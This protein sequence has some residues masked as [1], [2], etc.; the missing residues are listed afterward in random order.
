[1][2][3]WDNF[4]SFNIRHGSKIWCHSPPESEKMDTARHH[5]QMQAFLVSRCNIFQNRHLYYTAPL[6]H[7]SLRACCMKL[8]G[9]REGRNNILA[10]SAHIECNTHP[11]V[12]IICF[13]ERIALLSLEMTDPRKSSSLMSSC[14]QQMC[15]MK[16][17]R[18]KYHDLLLDDSYVM[19]VVNR[20][21]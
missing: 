14:Q 10:S 15:D 18:E 4:Y 2:K 7:L 12:P 9:G 19:G 1:M 17:W 5:H 16:M 13:W 20:Q 8:K 6:Y 3:N 11:C 21:N